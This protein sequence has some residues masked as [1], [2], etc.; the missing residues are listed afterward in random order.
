MEKVLTSQIRNIALLGHSG[1]GKT[2]L[3]E[4]MLYLSH[5]IDRMGNAA[6]GNTVSDYDPEEIKRG[7]SIQLAISQFMWK[8]V[9][10]NLLDTPGF[11]GFIGEQWQGIRAA[12]A[13][14]ILVDGK[15][16]I[17]VGTELAWDRATAAGLPKMFFVNKF[18]DPEC[19]FN[20][21]FTQLH[22]AFGVSVCPL[23]IPQV[24]GDTVT[25]FI[26]LVEQKVYVFDKAGNRTESPIPDEYDDV[27][28]KYTEMLMEAVAGTSE[29]LMEKY[30]AGEPLTKEE[31]L[32][33]IHEGIIHGSIV[34]VMCGSATKTWGV[35]SL[36][37]IIDGSFPRHTAK[38][39]EK[40]EDGSDIAIDKEGS[41]TAIFVFKTVSDPFVG[42]MSFFKVMTGT[43]DNTMVLKNLKTGASEKIARIYNL[44]GKKQ[45]E[46]EVLAC[47]DIGM[48][49]KLSTTG[50]GDTLVSN[51][52]MTAYAKVN[53]P[54]PTMTMAVQ[55]RAKGDEDKIATGMARLLEEDQTIRFENDSE[56]KQLLI[57]GMGDMHLDI[58]VS[59][60]KTR[61]NVTVDLIP[62]KIAYRESIRKTVQ[63]EGKHKKQSGGHGQY[64]HVK[65]T[66]SPGEE[67][68]L[69]F[70]QSVVGGA[71]PKNFY[72]AVEKGLQESMLR[73]VLAGYPMVSLKA[74]LFDGSYHDV[75]SSEMAFKI[76]ASLAY[77]D[78]LARAN[79]VLL[80]PVGQLEVII[81]DDLVGDVLG[82]LPKRRGSILGMAAQE[83]HPGYQVIS[84][85]VPKAEM[86][87]YTIALRA[88]TQGKGTFTYEITRYEEV[89]A[90]IAEKIIAE[91]KKNAQD[92]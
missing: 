89:P 22:D 84:A 37:D 18:D 41:D 17:E 24:E 54:V 75:D 51:E 73:G 87:D 32:N 25:G 70:T 90:A 44:R 63:A 7:N 59:R 82:D 45:T 69:T 65:I 78:G 9:K 67:E 52:S 20:R 29:E 83:H 62:Q 56:T 72:P 53:F 33:G 42:K 91:A 55:P 77:K 88:M 26:N 76:A 58:I 61:Y 19:R 13:A 81:P 80:E 68:G 38:K 5:N 74:D 49:T 64:G 40:A 66:F 47:G 23:M 43:L 92:D 31:V 6:D 12:D 35:S 4:A 39:V 57:S 28:A 46:V 85:E 30:F 15:A 14:I 27:T 79:P 3:N 34:P 71:V 36:L 1:A 8:S 86:V 48:L 21:V 2:A 11:P 16:G 60:L 50:T 10:I